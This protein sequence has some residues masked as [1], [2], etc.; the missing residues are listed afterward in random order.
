MEDYK[1][2]ILE[3]ETAKELEESIESFIHKDYISKVISIQFA[4][5]SINYNEKYRFKALIYYIVA[6]DYPTDTNS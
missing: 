2:R 6:Y 1:V 3:A 5:D 4:I